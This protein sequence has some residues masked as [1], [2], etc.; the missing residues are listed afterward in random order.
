MGMSQIDPRTLELIHVELDGEL[1]GAQRAELEA[2]LAADPAARD[3]REQWRRINAALAQLP[4]VEPPAGLGRR[5]QGGSPAAPVRLTSRPRRWLRPAIG[6][7]AGG[8]ALALALGYGG[9]GRQLLDGN[10]MVGTIGG[11]SSA[12]GARRIPVDVEG[13][14]GAIALLPSATGWTLD[15]DLRSERATPVTATWEPS[16]MALGEV[17][18][19]PPKTGFQAGPGRIAFLVDPAQHL[20]VDLHAVEGGQVRIRIQGPEGDGRELG[21]TVPP[22]RKNH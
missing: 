20:S 10:A 3:Y 16:A 21:I 4:S 12:D 11:A 5:W 18:G 15:F 22:A 7:A 9:L 2:R 6:L 8:M 17:R 14:T 19:T 1:D 13:V